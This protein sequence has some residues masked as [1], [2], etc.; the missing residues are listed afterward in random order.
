MSDFRIDKVT[1]KDGSAGT[2]IAGITTFS[3]TSGMV[4]PG[5]PTEYRGGRGRAVRAGGRISPAQRRE[6]DYVEIATTGNAVSFGDLSLQSGYNAAVSSSTRGVVQLAG[7]PS[8]GSYSTKLDYFIFSSQGGVADFGN[9]T[10]GRIMGKG[11]VSDGTRGV[12]AGGRIG[13]GVDTQ[14]IDYI[15]IASTGDATE[16]GELN[17]KRVSGAHNVTS[18]TRGLF[19]GG[20][21]DP[22]YETQYKNIQYITIQTKGDSK[23]FGELFTGRYR[24]TGCSSPTRG[25]FM[26]GRYTS[27]A[28]NTIS[29]INLIDYVTMASLGNAQDFGD[30]NYLAG[31]A[32]GASSQTRG[33]CMGGFTPTVVNQISYVTIASTG[34]GADFGDLTQAVDDPCAASDVHGGLG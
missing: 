28:P 14:V 26:G 18:P 23:D 17:K 13:P 11:S 9:L 4:M 15:T 33:L 12:F 1:N 3:G 22:A 20:Y 31:G 10:Q 5:G 21:T 27:S 7:S 34:N 6:M 2:Q 8:S 19:G 30:L 32:A 25:L 29:S 16:F 24:L